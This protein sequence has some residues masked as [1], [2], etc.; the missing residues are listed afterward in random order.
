MFL[1]S[2]FTIVIC[3]FSEESVVRSNMTGL[4]WK[5]RSCQDRASWVVRPV[6]RDRTVRKD[7]IYL[8][9]WIWAKK[10]RTWAHICRSY[11]PMM[12]PCSVS[13]YALARCKRWQEN[14]QWSD[15]RSITNFRTC[16]I[17]LSSD[18]LRII[19]PTNLKLVDLNEPAFTSCWGKRRCLTEL[20]AN[21]ME[22][23]Q[24]PS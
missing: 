6:R 9:F 19:S 7:V 24:T 18:P 2:M 4:S 12:L 21:I 1:S 3:R 13:S 15:S 20:T 23:Q 14:T 11:M 16:D 8:H 5:R 10:G 22:F 17:L